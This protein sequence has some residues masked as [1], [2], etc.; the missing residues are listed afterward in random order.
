MPALQWRT[1]SKP[2]GGTIVCCGTLT[3]CPRGLPMFTKEHTGSSIGPCVAVL[4]VVRQ[5]AWA[6]SWGSV[7]WRNPVS[8]ANQF[9]L[10]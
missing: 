4:A 3:S 5:D 6:E 7:P 1:V 2:T 10:L 9:L 8:S